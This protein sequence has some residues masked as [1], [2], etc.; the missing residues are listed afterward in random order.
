MSQDPYSELLAALGGYFRDVYAPAL[1]RQTMEITGL[2]T[3]SAGNQTF[4][5]GKI[6]RAEGFRLD[7]YGQPRLMVG[8]YVWAV[9]P[10]NAPLEDLAYGGIARAD[11]AGAGIVEILPG[12]P[13]TFDAVPF[14]YGSEVDAYKLMATARV[15]FVPP[16]AK[17]NVS[18]IMVSYRENGSTPWTDQQAPAGVTSVLIKDLYPGR[19]YDFKLRAVYN[20]ASIPSTES[21]VL[22][23]AMPAD[24]TSPGSVA[25]MS[26]APG[27]PG[28]L[29]VT[30]SATLDRRV[31]S[32]FRFRAAS[33]PSGPMIAEAVLDGPWTFSGAAG[34]YYFQIVPIGDDGRLGTAFPSASTYSGPH[35]IVDYTPPDVT[36]PPTWGAPTV[37]AYY[38]VQF[39]DVARPFMD[40]SFPAYS[41]PTDY[42]LTRI[43]LVGPGTNYIETTLGYNGSPHTTLTIPLTA[44]GLWTVSLQGQ[45]KAGNKS[46]YGSGAS[47]TEAD[48][49]LPAAAGNVTTSS[50]SL[51]VGL[52]WAL[53]ARAER[54]KVWRATSAAGAGA[55]VIATVDGDRYFDSFATAASIAG[56]IYYYKIQA[57]NAA[58]DGTISTVWTAGTVGAYDGSNLV[59]A[60]VT[61]AK[62]EVLL[63]LVS[64][65]M[66]T[67]TASGSR[68]ELRGNVVSLPNRFRAVDQVLG[69]DYERMVLNGAGLTVY[70][71]A[72]QSD[73]SMTR[74][75]SGRGQ[76]A[77][78]GMTAGTDAT[79]PFISIPVSTAGGTGEVRFSGPTV[80]ARIRELTYGAITGLGVT[81][82]HGT[83]GDPV[84]SLYDNVGGGSGLEKMA[85][86]WSGLGVR[87]NAITGE[88]T[89]QFSPTPDRWISNRGVQSA[90]NFYIGASD[91][92]GYT[93]YQNTQ[94][95]PTA[96]GTTGGNSNNMGATLFPTGTDTMA[97][98]MRAYRGQ[99]NTN[100]GDARFWLHSLA[101]GVADGGGIQM[102]FR[103]ASDP[104]VGL[105]TNT[106]ARDFWDNP[107]TRM[108]IPNN[109]RVDGALSKGSGTFDIDHP[110]PAKT[111]THR[112]RH[113]FTESPTRG[114]NLYTYDVDLTPGRDDQATVLDPEGKPVAGAITRHHPEGILVEIPLPDY[115]PHLNQDPRAWA[116]NVGEGWGQ[117]KATVDARLTTLRLRLQEP[118]RYQI[119]LIGTRKDPAA[120]AGWDRR[121]VEYRQGQRVDNSATMERRA[122]RLDARK[123]A[124]ENRGRVAYALP[125]LHQR[126]AGAWQS[127]SMR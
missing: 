63:A 111:A 58:G 29:V 8:Q 77:A 73:V 101:H 67:P 15:Q 71:D 123:R 103:N 52:T 50:I 116:S 83:I 56:T 126:E 62:L 54:I 84:L 106:T 124:E 2:E 85:L 40:V 120:V 90:G 37:N 19:T 18:A 95:Y 93:G 99:N 89:W 61:A 53:P 3:D 108:Q 122:A 35:V 115:W 70:G 121:G 28:Q 30:P 117:A 11:S 36:A 96:L 34:S 60:T 17:W 102:G 7:V 26:V 118:G 97:L 87:S 76:I 119:L 22:T 64:T 10:V 91:A 105:F 86:Y 12:P 5:V 107:N 21:G 47:D 113:S 72:A 100:K 127:L 42:D 114:Q 49:G 33:G 57:S 1:A 46:T 6:G 25:G 14:V 44:F 43:R 38:T 59:A 94:N 74:N 16:E 4:A 78:G 112:L 79:G 20:W 51:G 104:F 39:D 31:A 27:T 41:Y 45:D 65:L 98:V 32:G 23:V 88:A 13:P 82:L 69:V 81:K 55:A 109:L 80:S 48:P 9:F 75:A 125:P 24:G 66:T 110:D 92:L 68:L